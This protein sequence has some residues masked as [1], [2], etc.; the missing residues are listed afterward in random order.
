MRNLHGESRLT[1]LYDV[2][3]KIFLNKTLF[4]IERV[5]AVAR[6]RETTQPLMAQQLLGNDIIFTTQTENSEK[7]EEKV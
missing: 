7:S 1:L 3:R 6:E 2:R 4:D 5:S